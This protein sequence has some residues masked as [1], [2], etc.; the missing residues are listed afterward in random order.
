MK[1]ISGPLHEVLTLPT[2]QIVNIASV[3]YK[4][5]LKESNSILGENFIFHL[6]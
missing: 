6:A 5:N 2:P 1:F 3:I 4:V